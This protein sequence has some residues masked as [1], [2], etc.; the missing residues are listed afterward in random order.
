M[1]KSIQYLSHCCERRKAD[2]GTLRG[3]EGMD[4]A[5]LTTAKGSGTY[6]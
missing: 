1:S 4:I 6:F 3:T 5:V 2:C